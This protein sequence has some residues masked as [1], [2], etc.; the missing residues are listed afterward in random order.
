MCGNTAVRCLQQRRY[1]AV[2]SVFA[3]GRKAREK[4]LHEACSKGDTVRLR[5]Y[6]H[7]GKK[8]RKYGRTGLAAKAIQ[9]GCVRARQG[10]RGAGNGCTGLA[11]RADEFSRAIFSYLFGVKKLHVYFCI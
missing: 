1:S 11:A 6:S 9:C 5:P 2:A 7:R 8:A 10:R 3:Q 4:R